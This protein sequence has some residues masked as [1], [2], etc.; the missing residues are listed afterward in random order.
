MKRFVLAALAGL[1]FAVLAANEPL[2]APSFEQSLADA[3]ARHSPIFVDFHAPWCHSCFFMEKHVLNGAEWEAVRKKALT[4]EVDSDAPEGAAVASR[5]DI[6][7][8][9]TYVVLDENGQEIGRILGD[10]TR[11]AFYRELDALLDHG[12]VLDQWKSRVAGTG[13]QS[14]AAARAVLNAYYERMD[15]LGG[16]A[17]LQQLPDATRRAV[18]ADAAA[19]DRADR[20][21][22]LAEAQAK[23]PAACLAA[24][25]PVLGGALDCGNLGEMTEFVGCF[26][27]MPASERAMRLAP[28]RPKIAEA[29]R[30]LLVDR[31]SQCSDTRGVVEAAVQ[32]YEAIGDTAGAE[33]AWRQG[34]AFSEAGLGGDLARDH[35]LAD[36]LRYYLDQVGDTAKLDAL[37]PKLIAAY[38]DSYDYYLRYGKHLAKRGE[39][40]KAL[41]YL[42]Q[43][44]P[45][46]YGR[47]RL[48]VAQWRAWSLLKLGRDAEARQVA[49]EALRANGPWFENEIATLRATFQG[50]APG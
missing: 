41:P 4:I 42:E 20:L 9:P 2:G 11:E 26:D 6:K 35:H 27:E 18:S 17:W 33:N 50:K 22:L 13:P 30:R 37:F 31:T 32:F 19:R 5:F 49:S 21:T 14:I 7:G 36:N 29:Q 3:K 47:N 15:P 23:D 48:W 8:W 25:S 40:A 1:P 34:I 38:P 44:A 12:A 24:A 28:Y 45:K 39:Y 10:R 46:S 16:L 43:A